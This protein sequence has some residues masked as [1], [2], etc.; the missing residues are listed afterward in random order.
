MVGYILI[1]IL[2]RK[3]KG[4]V[5]GDEMLKMPS[6]TDSE[7]LT[8]KLEQRLKTSKSLSSALFKTYWKNII[9]MISISVSSKI[10][11]LS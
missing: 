9:G 10:T 4:K 8:R 1:I 6:G 11:I 5:Q 7:Y 3:V 2:V